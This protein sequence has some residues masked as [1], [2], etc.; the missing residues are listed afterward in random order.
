MPGYVGGVITDQKERAISHI[1]RR[2]E[3]P[4]RDQLEHLISDFFGEL[5]RHIGLDEAGGY[6]IDPD[7]A[8]GQLLCDRFGKGDEAAFT[9]GVIRL[10]GVAHYTYN[11][12]DIHD[13]AVALLHHDL[14]DG[15]RAVERALEVDPKD[16]IP[17]RFR[18]PDKKAVPGYAGIVNKYIDFLK[19]VKGFLDEGIDLIRLCDVYCPRQDSSARRS[20]ILTGLGEGSFVHVAYG[21]VASFPGQGKGYLPAYTPGAACYECNLVFQLHI[22]AYIV[23]IYY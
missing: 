21:D 9:R 1:L 2:P 6:R 13:P 10:A 14:G 19:F 5:G 4:Q 8:G 3:F 11:R 23:S 22:I 7:V 18:H 17:I 15:L 12:G 20:D 16:D